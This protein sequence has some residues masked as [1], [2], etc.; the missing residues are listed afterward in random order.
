MKYQVI[1]TKKAIT[2]LK[3]LGNKLSKF[4]IKKIALYCSQNNP[5]KYSKKLKTQEKLYRFRIGYFRA[6]FK[7]YQEKKFINLIILA[8]KHRKEIYKNI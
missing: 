8:I 4:I 7:I 3:N 2:Q 1:Y 6:I 5:L